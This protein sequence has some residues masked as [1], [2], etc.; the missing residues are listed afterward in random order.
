[1]NRNERRRQQAEQH[2]HANTLPLTLTPIPENEFPAGGVNPAK[3]WISRH[4]LVQLWIEDN[5][6]Y[7]GLM[8]LAVIRSRLTGGRWADGITWDELQ[9]IK[10]EVGFGDW[11]AI[12]IYPPDARVVNVSNMRHLWLLKKPL[13]IGW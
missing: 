6:V 1:M 8:R 11:Y 4:Y 3:A 9:L 12:E 7:P 2:K 5:P 10:R 13:A